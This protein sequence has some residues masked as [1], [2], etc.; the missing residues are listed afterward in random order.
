MQPMQTVVETLPFTRSAKDAGMTEAEVTDLIDMLADDPDYGNVIPGTGG[1]R[2]LRL[3]R[4]GKGKRGGY[5]IITFYSG[6]NIPVFL[7]RAFA[8]NVKVDL[9]KDEQNALKAVGKQIVDQYADM[10]RGFRR[11]P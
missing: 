4:R 5:R 2:K 9:S 11:V 10:F 8:K 6:V 7:I 3:A 1:F